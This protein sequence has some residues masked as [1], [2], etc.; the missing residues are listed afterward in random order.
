ML[1]QQLR[2]VTF[3]A[4]ALVR[5]SAAATFTCGNSLGYVS[6][7]VTIN[8][9]NAFI[10]NPVD[11]DDDGWCCSD[12]GNYCA[13]LTSQSDQEWTWSTVNDGNECSCACYPAAYT[14]DC[15]NPVGQPCDEACNVYCC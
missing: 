5:L 14:G 1:Y 10:L 8:I 9:G 3:M 15:T 4:I 13:T 11:G 2:V 6:C 7:T 12:D